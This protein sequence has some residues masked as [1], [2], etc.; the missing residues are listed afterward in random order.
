V[1]GKDKI[2]GG[3]QSWKSDIE[4]MLEILREVWIMQIRKVDLIFVEWKNKE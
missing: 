3:D 4:K 1:K 2:I